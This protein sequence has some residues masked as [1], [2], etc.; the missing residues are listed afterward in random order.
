MNNKIILG[1]GALLI[2]FSL[3]KPYIDKAIEN[4]NNNVPNV[5]VVEISDEQKENVQNIVDLLKTGPSERSGACLMLSGLYREMAVLIGLDQEDKIITTTGDIRQANSLSGRILKVE[6]PGDYD[7]L[8]GL[9]SEYVKSQ[10]GDKEV[11]LDDELRNKAVGAF[12]ALSWA[13]NEGAR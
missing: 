5:V 10:I 6:L 9:C 7:N 13:F 8:G 11:P 1:I 3:S 12:E 4:N 2:V